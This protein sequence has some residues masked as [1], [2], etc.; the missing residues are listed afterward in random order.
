MQEVHKTIKHKHL[1]KET[2]VKKSVE[3]PN[4]VGGKSLIATKLAD[5]MVLHGK[6]KKS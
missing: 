1:V 6:E 2:S 4:E 3:V 5:R